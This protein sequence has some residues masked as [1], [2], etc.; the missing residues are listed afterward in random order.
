MSPISH[1]QRSTFDKVDNKNS[2]DTKSKSA[3]TLLHTAEI[4]CC[5]ASVL[6]QWPLRIGK[7]FHT[8][9]DFVLVVNEKCKYFS[10]VRAVPD[11][12]YNQQPS[13]AQVCH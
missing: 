6:M 9:I 3:S 11:I 5:S 2:F 13:S 4:N 7:R 12:N 1:L 10:C 8:N